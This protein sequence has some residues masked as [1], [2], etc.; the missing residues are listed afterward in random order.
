M[1]KYVE[2]RS[3]YLPDDHAAIVAAAKAARLPLGVWVRGIAV[4]QAHRIAGG[5]EE[6]DVVPAPDP[7]R[8]EAEAFARALDAALARR[9]R[10]L[11]TEIAEKL[12]TSVDIVRR[13]RA[14]RG[15][16]P[17]LAPGSRRTW[18]HDRLRE[19]FASGLD[20]AQIAEATGWTRGTVRT[21]RSF[22]GL[23]RIVPG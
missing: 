15:I 9:P 7:E 21:R 1:T 8:T 4:R 11:D 6:A 12:N 18:D 17:A 2:V 5:L 22:L 13:H 16:A 10:L 3:Y 20:D 23:S 14:D 19:L